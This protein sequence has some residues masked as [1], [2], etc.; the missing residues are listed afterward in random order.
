MATCRFT[1]IINK[2]QLSSYSDR[3]SQITTRGLTPSYK[4]SFRPRLIQEYKCVERQLQGP[5]PAAPVVDQGP[6]AN[7]PLLIP[8]LNQLAQ[9][10]AARAHGE[11]AENAQEEAAQ[12]LRLLDQRRIT[13]AIMKYWAPHLEAHAGATTGALLHE[14]ILTAVQRL[15]NQAGCAT[16]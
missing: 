1:N 3:C 4:H 5:A 8:P 15:F 9:L 12:G 2:I 7:S 14:H 6:Q 11:N 10:R 13:A 16:T